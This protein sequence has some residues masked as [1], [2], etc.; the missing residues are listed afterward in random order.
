MT[1]S[2]QLK[3]LDYSQELI[4]KATPY[5]RYC[6]D[7]DYRRVWDFTIVT[8]VKQAM[9]CGI[10][11]VLLLE[12]REWSSQGGGIEMASHLAVVSGKKLHLSEKIVWRHRTDQSKDRFGAAWQ[13]IIAAKKTKSGFEVTVKQSNKKVKTVTI[14]E[15]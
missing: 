3:K 1:I 12:E 2:A 6:G 7:E 13:E 10:F 8:E 15:K 9:D 14:F 4:S 5:L 11:L